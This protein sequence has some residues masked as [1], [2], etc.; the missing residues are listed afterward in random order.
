MVNGKRM[1]RLEWRTNETSIRHTQS[2]SSFET[3]N[4]FDTYFKNI[5]HKFLICLTK[6]L[7]F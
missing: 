7:N 1:L 4:S 5:F 6:T 2:K 3:H